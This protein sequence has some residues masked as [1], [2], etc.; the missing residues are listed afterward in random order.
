MATLPA[1]AVKTGK[2]IDKALAVIERSWM[3]ALIFVV[4]LTALSAPISWFTVGSTAP[5][6]LLGGEVLK[7]ALGMIGAIGLS[8]V[9]RGL[10]FNV[11]PI[12]PATYA[13]IAALLGATVLAACWLPARRASS[14]S[15]LIATRGDQVL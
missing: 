1:R 5:L 8:Q 7:S 12:D 14:L 15:P 10:L 9:V 2:I 13:A 3:P 4:V 6:R 11:D